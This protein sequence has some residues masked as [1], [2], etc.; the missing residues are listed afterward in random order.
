MLSLYL[1]YAR[2]H[3][4][5]QEI[6]GSGDTRDSKGKAYV[7]LAIIHTRIYMEMLY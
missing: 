6:G 1:P 4:S 3:I 2:Q 7:Q 5:D